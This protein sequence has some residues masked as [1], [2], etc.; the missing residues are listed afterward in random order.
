ME[1]KKEYEGLKL[2]VLHFE[3]SDVVTTS[4]P[5][6]VDPVNKGLFD[7]EDFIKQDIFY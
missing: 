4:G 6:G 5:G 3:A 7:G 2:Q 1:N